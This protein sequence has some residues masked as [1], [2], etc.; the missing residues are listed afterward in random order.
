MLAVMSWSR[1]K[2]ISL[3]ALMALGLSVA[4]AS[5]A[6][7]KSLSELTLSLR[8][9]A[10]LSPA[11]ILARLQAG[12][13][14]VNQAIK[15]RRDRERAFTLARDARDVAAATVAGLKSNNVAGDALE[16]AL[17]TALNLDQEAARARSSL[18]DAE[19]QVAK[20]GAQLLGLYDAVLRL[21]RKEVLELRED[22][23]RRRKAHAAYRQLAERRDRVR[24]ALAPV[25][26]RAGG[27]SGGANLDIEPDDDV[28]VLLE[29]ADLARDLEERFLR[30][31]RAIQKRIRELEEQA[32]LARS[33]NELSRDESL[34]DE[35]SRR[36]LVAGEALTSGTNERR[37]PGG[38]GGLQNDESLAAAPPPAI[39]V[40]EGDSPPPPP[41]APAD[42]S[43][44]DAP[45]SEA[46]EPPDFANNVGGDLGARSDNDTVD[47]PVD[48]DPGPSRGVA[49]QIFLGA[50]DAEIDALISSGRV[51]LKQLKALQKKALT[52]ARQAKKKSQALRDEVKKRVNR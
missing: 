3:T 28:G 33:V 43:I 11:E 49:E 39:V 5:L 47:V 32:D 27:Q 21:K 20:A 13:G 8:T 9:M 25:L 6:Q 46:S 24:G 10:R 2:L 7:P 37:A 4:P 15:L 45:E 52:E 42:P 26:A 40:V 31:A 22:D 12:H 51:S 29:K 38:G 30:R 1:S 19:A 50:T 17:R 34:F 36:L 48:V 14:R 18:A 35:N 23:P 44:D 41:P 16:N